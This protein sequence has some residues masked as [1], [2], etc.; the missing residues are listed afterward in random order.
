MLKTQLSYKNA[1]ELKTGINYTWR[2]D[3]STDLVHKLHNLNKNINHTPKTVQT[4]DIEG[5]YD[6]IDLPELEKI[7]QIFTPKC[8]KIENKKY[9]TI[10]T[11]FKK[12]QW[13]N[14][15]RNTKTII[16]LNENQIIQLQNWQLN[17][18][19]IQYNNKTWKQIKGIAQGTNQ[20]PDLADII[21]GHYEHEFMKHHKKQKN[22][23]IINIFNNTTRKMDDILCI[24]N[25][26]INEW[27]YIDENQ[28]HEIYPK[29]YFTITSEQTKPTNEVN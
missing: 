11:Q 25:D 21:L 2:I 12:A 8:F 18:A 16:T 22:T 27:I 4:F 17:N 5:F 15:I 23:N 28:P 14:T 3:N 10:N 6:N 19:T 1:K 24:N 26:I 7:I 29:K 20:S 13:S 9:I